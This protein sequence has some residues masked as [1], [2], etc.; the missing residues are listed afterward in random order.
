MTD[1]KGATS[2]FGKS[3]RDNPHYPRVANPSGTGEEC[4]HFKRFTRGAALRPRILGMNAALRRDAVLV[5]QAA[6]PV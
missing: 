6:E 4:H 5:D 2:R 3:D 1:L